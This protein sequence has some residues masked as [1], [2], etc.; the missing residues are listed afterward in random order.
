MSNILKCGVGSI[1]EEMQQLPRLSPSALMTFRESPKHYYSRYIL[2]QKHVTPA[3]K[4][5]TAIHCALLEPEIF[6]KQYYFKPKLEDYPDALVTQNDLKA[7]C[8]ELGLPVT[9]T[10]PTL[11]KR[12]IEAGFDGILWDDMIA[13]QS[14]GREILSAGVEESIEGI[15]NSIAEHPAAKNILVGGEA[16]KSVVY[17]S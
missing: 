12:L 7:K 6:D 17:I 11:A 4:L 3:M 16:E 1:T 8:K 5:G 15:K 9:G 14:E 13:Q 2:G 10:K